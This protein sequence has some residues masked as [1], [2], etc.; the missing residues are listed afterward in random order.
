VTIR[1]LGPLGALALLLVATATLTPMVGPTAT[2]LSYAVCF[3]FYAATLFGV[4]AEKTDVALLVGVAFAVRFVVAFAEPI[5]SDDIFRYVWEGRV[6]MAGFNPFALAPNAP[7]LAALRDEVIWPR[8]NHPEVPTIYPPLAQYFFAAVAVVDGGTTTM[9]LGFV[10]VEALGLL[11]IWR[12]APPRFRTPFVVALYLLNPL[13]VLEVAW[14]G[15]LDVLAWI[16]LTLAL[17]LLA[18]RRDSWRTGAA[19]GVFLGLSI[20]AKFLGVLLLPYLALR[21]TTDRGAALRSRAT[22]LAVAA[23][24]VGV[25]YVGFADAGGK[26]FSGFGTYAASWRSN[27]GL[28]RGY[29]RLSHDTIQGD[30][31]G[32]KIFGFPQYDDLAMEWG[33]TKEWKGYVLPNT[34]FA[35]DQISQTVAKGIGALVG[36]LVLLFCIMAVRDPLLG[37]LILLGT[38]YFIAPTVHPWYV[39]WLVPVAALR[40]DAWPI[41]FSGAVLIAYAAWV[42]SSAGGE[43]AIPWWAVAFEYAA[44]FGVAVWEV[45]R[46]SRPGRGGGLEPSAPSRDGPDPAQDPPEASARNHAPA[47]TGEE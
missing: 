42:S 40:R 13:V 30:V 43:W 39:A 5:L 19:A 29:E 12:L 44:V 28:F 23:S 32:K 45:E 2:V 38:L 20:A 7:E 16:P 18:T 26:L 35:T 4:R 11:A 27:D 36:G 31:D 37:T 6:T 1:V 24:I 33:F 22:M 46:L 3:L 9:R 14:S 21:R 34:S 15:H 10:A 25:S 41:V 17:L 8:V 47:S